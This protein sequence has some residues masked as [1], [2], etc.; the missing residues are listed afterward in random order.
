VRIAELREQKRRAI[1]LRENL[2]ETGDA[3]DVRGSRGRGR[4]VGSASF[5]M[6]GALAAFAVLVLVHAAVW[7]RW[8]GWLAAA[9]AALYALRAGTLLATDGAFAADGLLGLYVPVAAVA[10]WVLIAS[11]TLALARVDRPGDAR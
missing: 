9:A 1:L 7:P 2:Y 11:V 5:V 6:A 3:R 8:V 4:D 10:G